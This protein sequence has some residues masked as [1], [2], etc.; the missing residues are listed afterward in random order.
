MRERLIRQLKARIDRCVQSGDPLAILD[1]DAIWEAKA[2]VGPNTGF[3]PE[4]AHTVGMLHWARYQAQPSGTAGEDL[5]VALR[6]FTAV[7]DYDPS[8]RTWPLPEPVRLI[9]ECRRGG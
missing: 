7:H 4:A 6:L 3:D 9:L 8:S 2:L 1:M 5:V